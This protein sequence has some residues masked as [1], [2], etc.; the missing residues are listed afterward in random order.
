MASHSR[1]RKNDS[2]ACDKPNKSGLLEELKSIEYRDIVWQERKQ[3]LSDFKF[4][5]FKQAIGTALVYRYELSRWQEYCE[6]YFDRFCCSPNDEH[7]HHPE[8][9]VQKGLDDEDF[10]LYLEREKKELERLHG[11]DGC[12]SFDAGCLLYA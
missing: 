7:D 3:L 12:S 10:K 9:W 11:K 6:K 1:S 8:G 2:T 4:A 5:R